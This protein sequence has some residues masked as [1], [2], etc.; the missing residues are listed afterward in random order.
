MRAELA[1]PAECLR[2]GIRCHEGAV[3]NL[4]LT[5]R[6]RL[7]SSPGLPDEGSHRDGLQ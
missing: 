1:A 7:L 4:R 2:A 5:L 3:G 6:V